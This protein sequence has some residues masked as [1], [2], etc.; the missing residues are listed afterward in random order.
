VWV[1]RWQ[2]AR[3]EARYVSANVGHTP[4][5]FITDAG[6]VHNP[7]GC[8]NKQAQIAIEPFVVKRGCAAIQVQLGP[9]TDPAQDRRGADFIG[10]ERRVVVGHDAQIARANQQQFLRHKP[11]PVNWR[12]DQL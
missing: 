11:P 9:V 1:A 8:R 4:D 10:T 5:P 3:R 6:R 2:I 12:D 7:F